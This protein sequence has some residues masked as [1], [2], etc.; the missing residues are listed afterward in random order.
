MRFDWAG[1]EAAIREQVVGFV[2]R[3]CA[4]HP[5]EHIYGA[6]VHEFYAESGGTIAWTLVGVASE[7]RLAAAASGPLDAQALRWSPA[8][9]PWQ[10]D[11]GAAEEEW[12]SRLEAAATAG[13]GRHW[14]S[15]HQR[16]LRT[17]TK[18]CTAARKQLVADGVVGKDFLV[19]A[20]DEAWELIPLS[21]TRAQV[22]QHF[23]ELDAELC[24][25]DRLA[26]CLRNSG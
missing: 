22:R 20:M 11:P 19:V 23:P 3:M 21:P 1:L 6:A 18:A 13:D 12:A 7:E 4:E 17:A 10:L 9:W 26:A 24:E 25:A 2:L 14:E 8:D 16:Y 15:V 5:D